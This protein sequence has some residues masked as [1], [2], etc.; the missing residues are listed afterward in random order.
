MTPTEY[1]LKPPRP[2]V[3]PP[4]R[5][6]GRKRANGE[7]SVYQRSD[8]LWVAAITGANG[9]RQR[10]YA[11]TRA[12]AG[13]RL[14]EV[15]QRR[16][17]GV[18]D[19]APGGRDTVATYLMA[20]LDG[21]GASVKP[22]T[23]EKYRRDITLH[24]LPYVG[25]LPLPRLTP[26]RLQRLYGDLAE[27]GL[28]SMSIRHVHAVVH[29]ALK[30]G[31]RWGK[32]ARN[33]ADL[34]DPPQAPRH[35]MQTLT[36][37]QVR[38][39][40][41]AVEEDRLGALYALAVTTGM[42]RGELLGLRW[43]DVDVPNQALA[44]TGS[45]QRVKGKGLVRVEP[46]TARSRR[47]ILLTPTAVAALGRHQS[48]QAVERLKAADWWQD[49][50]L[51]FCSV[52]GTPLEPGNMLRRSFHPLLI[53]AGLP[54]IRFHDLRHTAATVMLGRGV[55]P[56][57]ASEMLGHATVGITLDTYSHVTET[58][59]RTAIGAIEAALAE[60]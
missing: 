36:L 41:R 33:V 42:R 18:G 19:V 29:K 59:Q 7:G 22:A 37:E 8:G 51:V 6:R 56:K 25:R 15:L 27:A 3:E 23:G 44:V 20:W 10:L 12:E 49:Q 17:Q 39:L 21:L 60:G 38:T 35:E 52:V 31:V 43:S 34:V 47:R 24:V 54:S 53:R 5:P 11:H 26:Q 46:K 48:A 32:V 9:R 13:R 40:L 58:M 30:Q 1:S 55:H 14:T 50:D 16:D 2:P 57:I 4:L 45:L 28:S